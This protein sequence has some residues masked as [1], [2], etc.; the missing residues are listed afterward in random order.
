V[1][2]EVIPAIIGLL[3]GNPITRFLGKIVGLALLILSFGAWQ[4]RQGAQGAR[5]KQDRAQAKAE[6]EAHDRINEADLG[7]GATDAERVERLRDF[8]ADHG[9]GSAKGKGG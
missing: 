5:A 7:V 4:R 2:Q 8:A 1:G 6:R 3:T 9:A